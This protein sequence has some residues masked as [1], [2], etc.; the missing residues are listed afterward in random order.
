MGPICNQSLS[1]ETKIKLRQEM[2]EFLRKKNKKE[3]YIEEPIFLSRMKM[4]PKM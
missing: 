3:T 2:M 4:A 1:D